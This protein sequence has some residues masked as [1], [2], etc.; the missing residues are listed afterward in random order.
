LFVIC[1]AN[2]VPGITA[3][4]AATKPEKFGLLIVTVTVVA[5]PT[6]ELVVSEYIV[7]VT[8]PPFGL[9]L[10]L[11]SSPVMVALVAMTT[12]TSPKL[13]EV[14]PSPM[15]RGSPAPIDEVSEAK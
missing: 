4:L 9:P 5:V 6:E 2:A 15:K 13:P 7:A 1:T 3:R 8:V 10:S 11:S 12:A 14:T